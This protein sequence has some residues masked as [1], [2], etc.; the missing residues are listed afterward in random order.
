MSH[1]SYSA[2]YYQ[3]IKE[4]SAVSAA[5][6]AGAIVGAGS[7]PVERRCGGFSR[8]AGTGGDAPHQRAV[9]LL[10]DCVLSGERL[11]GFG[12]HTP[13]NLEQREG[14]LVVCPKHVC[15]H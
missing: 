15:F 7:L 2:G 6:R 12:L 14:R 13:L 11:P 4:D 5:R 3:S 8:R 1:L 9:A 10:L